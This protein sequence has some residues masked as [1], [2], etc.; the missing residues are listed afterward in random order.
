MPAGER[1]IVQAITHISETVHKIGALCVDGDWACAHGDF[2]AL[3]DVT[4]QLAA[5][6]PEPLHCWLTELADTCCGNPDRAGELWSGLKEC[7]Y[8]SAEPGTDK[9]TST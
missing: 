2:S 3:R 1:L 6:V 8:R 5:Y 9:K 4:L 7:I